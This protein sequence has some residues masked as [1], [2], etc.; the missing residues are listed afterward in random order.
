M[1]IQVN[2]WAM[3]EMIK[4]KSLLIPVLGILLNKRRKDPRL[5]YKLE[6]MTQTGAETVNSLKKIV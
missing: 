2:D 4:E 1:E 5:H 6:T 3:A